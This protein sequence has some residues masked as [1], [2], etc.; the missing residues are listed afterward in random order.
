MDEKN[1]KNYP[2]PSETLTKSTVSS[3][4]CTGMVPALPEDDENMDAY[5]ELYG[6]PEQGGLNELKNEIKKET[7]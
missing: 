7:K 6:I 1:S 2:D 4:D 5:N 3:T